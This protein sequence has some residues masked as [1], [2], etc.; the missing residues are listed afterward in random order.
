VRTLADERR[1]QILRRLELD[2]RVL[3][4]DL[5]R[6]LD[7]SRD[8]IRRDLE[9]LAAAGLLVRV[10]GGAI[11]AAVGGQPYHVRR[12]QAP[13]AKQA[14]A[15]AVARL[16]RPGSVVF[17]DAGTTALAVA[18][19]L[20]PELEATIAT[21]SPPAAVALADHP[22]VEVFFLGGRL[23]K[24]PIATVGAATLEAIAEI[25]ADLCVLGVCSLH[26]ELGVSVTDLE[27][28]HI[29]RAM[30]SRSAEVVAATAADKLGS[31]GPFVVGPIDEL[32]AIV[33]DA[34]AA[35]LAPYREAG[36][37]VTRV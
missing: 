31:Q 29:K 6:E 2:N 12:E 36:I 26:P 23:A 17:L 34:P 5:V 24:A 3:A 32:T 20:A 14:I 33:T 13:E 22:R 16:I 35:V 7:V 30:I 1:S 9:D 27:E 11:P 18:R 15:R 21:N 10:H 8:T 37:T 28:A 4:A 25:N 19:A